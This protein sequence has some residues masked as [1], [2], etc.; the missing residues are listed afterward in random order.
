MANVSVSLEELLES[1]AHFG[2]QAR[3]WNPRM[4]P[5]LYGVKEGVHVF[6]LVK[7]RECL[8]AAL[9]V[10]ENAS[11]GGK[12]ILL[13]GTKKQFKNKVKEVAQNT[14]TMYVTER[15]LGG[16]LTNFQQISKSIRNLSTMKEKFAK[17]E[18]NNYTKKERLLL[19]R[20]MQDLEKSFG[21]IA[22]LTKIPDLLVILDTHK[23][24][25][26]VREA[27]VMGV[28]TIGIV[29]SNADPRE[30]T[31]PV[32]MNDDAAKAVEFVLTLFEQAL[33]AGK[34]PVKVAKK[35]KKDA[36]KSNS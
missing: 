2:H 34:K 36:K 8:L 5:Y 24:K 32:P 7:T 35:N 20:K 27:K 16:T 22:Q 14:G 1:G 18:Y 15:F 6:D 21:G 19:D 9:E 10:L 26:A 13:V 33:L 4:Q 12:T 29:D 30:V 23:E 28:P 17:G 11:R 31:Y 25:G 3:R